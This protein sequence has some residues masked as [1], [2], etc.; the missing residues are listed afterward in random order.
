[1]ASKEDSFLVKIKRSLDERYYRH[2][3]RM[4]RVNKLVGELNKKKN[5]RGSEKSYRIPN[6]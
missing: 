1:M 6:D 2:Q 4:I 5:E 3:A